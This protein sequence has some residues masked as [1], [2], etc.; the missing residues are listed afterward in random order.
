TRL[1][2]ENQLLR[3]RERAP[4]RLELAVRRRPRRLGGAFRV[5]DST[6]RI[7]PLARGRADGGLE[8][9]ACAALLPGHLLQLRGETAVLRLP[10]RHPL[11]LGIDGP[12]GLDQP[13]AP[14]RFRLRLTGARGGLAGGERRDLGLELAP[15]TDRLRGGGPR[16]VQRARDLVA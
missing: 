10:R 14:A 4:E 9:G 12:L 13:T 5:E 6:E 3:L 7:V 11:A 2:V 16:I 8:L 15:A 1:G